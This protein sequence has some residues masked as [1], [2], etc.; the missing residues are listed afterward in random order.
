[1]NT[2]LLGILAIGTALFG[3][4]LHAEPA[5]SDDAP[6]PAAGTRAIY[7]NIPNDQIEF[8]SSPDRI[9]SAVAG[10]SMSLIWETLEHGERVECLDCIPAVEPLLYDANPR[11]REI[12]AWWLRRRLF[13]VFGPGE[14]YE[15]TIG[16]LKND[17]NPQRRAYAANALGEFL[18]AP[19]IDACAEAVQK[20]ADPTVRAAAA[21]AL[22]R[23]N[24]DGKGAL[25]KALADGDARVKLAALGSATRVNGFGDAPA[26]AALLGDRDANVRRRSAEALGT[27]RAKDASAALTALAKNDP[28][29]NVRSAACHTLGVVGDAQARPVLEDLAKNDR[30]GFVRDM[31]QI[32]LRR[33]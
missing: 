7:G 9:K 12:A 6:D 23:L 24:D 33:L 5:Y 29:P 10:G 1:M 14:V 15:K 21:S 31:A 2:R 19:G 28:D 27:L 16:V 17:P 18:S 22:G 32:A 11:T 20:D 26:V 30:D 25:S 13:G 8:L 3:T 4:I